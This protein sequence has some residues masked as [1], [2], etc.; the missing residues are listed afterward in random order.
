MKTILLILFSLVGFLSFSQAPTFDWA[1]RWGYQTFGQISSVF[2]T[3]MAIDNFGNSYVLSFGNTQVNFNPDDNPLITAPSQGCG[4]ISKYNSN[5]S[6]IWV[7]FIV[8]TGGTYGECTPKKIFIKNNFIYYTGQINTNG[9]VDFDFSNNSNNLSG[10]LSFISKIDLDGNFQWVKE[11]GNNSSNINDISVDN[12]ENVLIT[13]RFQNSLSFDA[14]TITSIGG[15]DIF[16]AKFDLNGNH[17]WIKGFGG[18]TSFIDSG[19]GIVTAP[20]GD[21]Y[22]IGN[23]EGAVDFDP[24]VGIRVSFP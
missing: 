18:S 16:V 8:K 2:A 13:G 7:K 1:K 3:D 9:L 19:N 24:N 10:S 12:L 17:I 20:N 22:V 15:D 23:F 4:A 21:I 11:F 6:L 14:Q 5:G